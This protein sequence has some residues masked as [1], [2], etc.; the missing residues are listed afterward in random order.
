MNVVRID[1]TGV[2]SDRFDRRSA[3]KYLKL[4]KSRHEGPICAAEK[5]PD[6]K[7]D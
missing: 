7:F 4:L 5:S 1:F 2:Q 3:Y 6:G